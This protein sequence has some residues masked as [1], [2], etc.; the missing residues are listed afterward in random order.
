MNVTKANTT[1]EPNGWTAKAFRRLLHRPEPLSLILLGLIGLASLTFVGV[2]HSVVRGHTEAIDR[3]ILLALRQNGQPANPVGPVWLEELMRDITA[4]GGNGFVFL[5]VAV[6][7]GYLL[8]EQQKRL[9]VF[10]LG[11]IGGGLLLS[12]AL[13]GWIGRARPDL[14]AHGQQVMTASFPSMHSTMA[15][16]CFLSVAIVLGRST[17]RRALRSYLTGVGVTLAL[18]VGFSRVYLGVHW[19]TDVIAGW[20]L[21]A[22]WAL[23]CFFMARRLQRRNL[24]ER[25]S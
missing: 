13:K 12:L 7:V 3:S 18:L 4:L 9:A 11:S 6:V 24:M 1:R 8:L 17:R 2:W 5:L 19:P 25:G 22:G 21:G 16:A 14:V 20:T 10:L 15:T 23:V